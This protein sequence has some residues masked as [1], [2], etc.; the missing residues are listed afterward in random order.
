[1][2]VL[3]GYLV[4]IIFVHAILMVF[5]LLMIHP[6]LMRFVIG[7]FNDLPGKDF[8]RMMLNDSP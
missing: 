3:F 4:E 5:L 8:L 6:P 1:M 2:N 7:G